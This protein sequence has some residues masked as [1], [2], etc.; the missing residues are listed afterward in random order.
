MT[1]VSV[2]VF[3]GLVTHPATR[4]PASS[5][6]GGLIRSLAIEL[7]RHGLSSEVVI[8]SE[9]AWSPTL[10]P[11]DVGTVAR[12]INAELDVEAKWRLWHSPRTPEWLV[13]LVMSARRL[14]RRRKFLPAGTDVT[15]KH[16][17]F[18]M[19]RRLANI[20]LAHLA[21]LR[22]ARD[23]GADWALI[24]EDDASGSAS[25]T[26][27]MLMSLLELTDNQSQPLYVNVSR[28]FSTRALRIN[29]HLQ[30]VKSSSSHSGEEVCFFRTEK[31]VTNTVCAVLYRG[32][33][34]REL[35]SAMDQ[36]PMDPII[37]IDWKLNAALM[38][39]WNKR[40]IGPGDCWIAQPAPITQA[41]MHPQ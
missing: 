19:V 39:L 32:A 34:L 1:F 11:I 33:F 27:E 41:S 31:P 15:D 29:K 3:L 7:D 37:P 16:P 14:Y 28:S 30:P 21:L 26:T 10:L 12:S 17:G 36:I 4:F 24:L 23:S 13:T 18:T 9:N 22:A 6:D 5:R 2:D 40:K 8:F 38:D 25:D 35:V 20:E